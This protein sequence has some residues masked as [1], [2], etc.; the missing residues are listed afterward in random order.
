MH[1]EPGVTRDRL[2]GQFEYDSRDFL[3]VDTGGILMG[4]NKLSAQV[5]AQALAAVREA[6]LVLMV[7]DGSQ[8]CTPLDQMVESELR[9]AE[10]PSICIVNK[11]DRKDCSPE[12]F[13]ALGRDEFVSISAEHGLD[14]DVLMDKVIAELDAVNWQWDEPTVSEG[15]ERLRI[16]VVGRPN[17]GKS[18]LVNTLLGEER[19]VAHDMPGTT[20][21]VIDIDFDREGRKYTLL[22]TAGIRRKARTDEAVEIFSVIKSVRTMERA[23]LV[24][25]VLDAEEGVTHQDRTLLADAAWSHRPVIIALNKWDVVRSANVPGH[26]LEKYIE[27]ARD[28]LGE[29]NRLPITHI[30][31]LKGEGLEKLWELINSYSEAVKRRLSTRQL[32]LIS[33]AAQNHHHIPVYRDKPVKI[34]YAT[35]V[36]VAPPHL[37]FFAN[38][39]E[40]IPESYQRYI[41]KLIEEA[42][43]LPG[44]P[45]RITL[46]KRK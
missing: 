7:V 20:R 38:Y 5:T 44:I 26:T 39:P 29:L 28:V 31:A 23:D 25:H 12:E 36:A 43:G 34:Y 21:D 22:D 16:A 1:D 45:V 24:V 6:D 33:E 8:G 19:V 37:V 9:K 27:G 46:R 18:T 30:S 4:E 2:Y 17:V 40:G 10:R 15:N 32:N 42:I 11:T 41:R 3:L 14:I 13:Y 35:Q